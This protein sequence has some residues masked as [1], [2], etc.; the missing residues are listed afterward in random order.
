MGVACHKG[1]KIPLQKTVRQCFGMSAKASKQAPPI[2]LQQASHLHPKIDEPRIGLRVAVPFRMCHNGS[3]S[4]LQHRV[5]N[6][7][8]GPG[9]ILKWEFNQRIPGPCQS[10]KLPTLEPLRRMRGSEN[11][12]AAIHLKRNFRLLQCTAKLRNVDLHAL[13]MQADFLR[14]IAVRGRDH[15]LYAAFQRQL[16]HL[17]R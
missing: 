12:H 10:A 13:C 8:C 1:H 16:C 2:D 4:K 17:Q 5:Q 14:Q 3:K 7:R 11:L 6:L 15:S 9:V